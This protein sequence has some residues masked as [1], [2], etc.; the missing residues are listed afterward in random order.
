M[1]FALA[2]RN[3]RLYPA[4]VQGRAV[5]WDVITGLGFGKTFTHA[6][7]RAL[8]PG[9]RLAR[10]NYGSTA[11]LREELQQIQKKDKRSLSYFLP[12]S[13]QA[14]PDLPRLE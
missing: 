14:L 3:I 8:Y 11:S 4:E 13:G 2:R 1:D 5:K 9:Q 12:D 7:V 10:W 6:D